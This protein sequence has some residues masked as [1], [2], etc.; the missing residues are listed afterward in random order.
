MRCALLLKVKVPASR[1]RSP[2][3]YI[4]FQTLVDSFFW[5]HSLI[6]RD[7]SSVTFSS[8]AFQASK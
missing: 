5:I 8:P 4:Q 6:C 3:A 1:C 2:S 7:S